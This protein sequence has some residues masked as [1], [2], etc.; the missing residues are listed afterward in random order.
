MG[1]MNPQFSGTPWIEDPKAANS[2]NSAVAEEVQ[3]KHFV[4]R[5]RDIRIRARVLL[6]FREHVARTSELYVRI[7][8]NIREYQRGSRARPQRNRS[9]AVIGRVEAR[10]HTFRRIVS[11]DHVA[12]TRRP[13]K[14]PRLEISRSGNGDITWAAF[15]RFFFRKTLPLLPNDA[16]MEAEI[17]CQSRI[18]Q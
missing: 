9:A 12:G 7:R 3:Q 5:R 11:W 18:V 16:P 10:R 8:G 1:E 17:Q 4:V 13:T 15:T 2:R 14:V 6:E